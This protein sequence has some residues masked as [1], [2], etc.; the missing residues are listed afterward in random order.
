MLQLLL[1]VA[2]AALLAIM[3][4][5][6]R[7]VG[8]DAFINFRVVRQ[9]QAGHGPVFN[10]GERVEAGT[11]PLWIMILFAADVVTP[12]RLEWI[13][14]VLGIGLT[15]TGLML[16]QRG[17]WHIVQATHPGALVVPFGALLLAALPPMWDYATSGLEMGLAFAWLG[18]CFWGLARR[19]HRSIESAGDRTRPPVWLCILIGLGPL[20]RP[21][22]AIFSVV[23]VAAAFVID[24]GRRRAERGYAVAAMLAL[25]LGSEL[26]RMG[27]YASLVPNTALTKESALVNWAQGWR[28]LQNYGAPYWLWVP[29]LVVVVVIVAILVTGTRDARRLAILGA[30][31]VGALL[32][33]VYVVRVG[34]DFMHARLLLPATFAA[35]LPVSVLVFRGWSRVAVTTMILWALICALSLRAPFPTV[36]ITD[37]RRFWQRSTK[38]EHPIT[39]ADFRAIPGYQKGTHARALE[40]SGTRALALLQADV[41]LGS[42]VKQPVVVQLGSAGVGGYLAP[43]D[44]YVIDT[45]GLA[46]PIGSRLRI[47]ERGR[48]GH[49]KELLQPWM[50]ARFTDADGPQTT[51]GRRALGCGELRELLEATSGPLGFTDILRNL[52]WAPRLTSLRIAREPIVAEPELCG[53]KR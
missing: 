36:T 47:E 14:V 49:E 32:H 35:I 28:Y 7:W 34:G 13:A 37:E 20:V 39:V 11:S 42:K 52:A 16:A 44:A 50:L 31:V 12:L 10:A 48:P 51:P 4:W 38:H 2:P 43:T 27:Y 15:I 21:D 22:F 23:F 1:L 24:P 9:I 5:Q 3:A 30:P 41:P 8:D 29:L 26:F 6:H 25:P 45:L 33:A 19:Y 46:D 18:A 53:G 17:A 40:A